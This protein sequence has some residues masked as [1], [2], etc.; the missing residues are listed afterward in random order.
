MFRSR[1]IR[2]AAGAGVSL[3][4]LA[5]AFY[6]VRLSEFWSALWEVNV[7]SLLL[8]LWFFI[9][10]CVFRAVM[11]R[12]TSRSLAQAAFPTLFGGVIIG[13]MANNLL[14]LRAGELVRSYYFSVR[15]DVSCTA[16][17]STVCVER[18]LD[19]FS[20]LLLLMLGLCWGVRG[21]VPQAAVVALSFLALVLLIGVLI[22]TCLARLNSSRQKSPAILLNIQNRVKE[23]IQ[24]ISKLQQPKTLV[25][26]IGLSLA[27]WASN[28]VSML[29]LINTGGENQLEAALLLLLFVNL[30]LLVPSTPGALG[31]MQVAFCMALVPFGL[32]Q[33][34]ALAH[35]FAYQIGIVLLTVA[36]G[37][38]YFMGA[39]LR[40]N[41]VP[42]KVLLNKT[43]ASLN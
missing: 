19:V 35:S 14:P 16:A 17:F 31:V 5:G 26:L 2:I 13:Y 4:F 7:F 1:A 12:I 18:L 32:L 24:P 37:F 42:N 20:L 10:N 3:I 29:V 34:Q 8:C 43:D 36:L 40:L 25:A 23:F 6:N 21:L 15:A 30:G 33:E 38:P 41:K 28:Y 9:L 11:W 27:A 22:F 39:H